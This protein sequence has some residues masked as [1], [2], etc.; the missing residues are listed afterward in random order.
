MPTAITD[1]E[2]LRQYKSRFSLFVEGI[3]A[4]ASDTNLIREVE[5]KSPDF[6]QIAWRYFGLIKCAHA[7]R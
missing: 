7:D 2:Y 1:T 5:S 6:M 3:L 4:F